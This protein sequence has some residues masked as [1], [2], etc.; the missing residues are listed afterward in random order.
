L[1]LFSFFMDLK[2]H[3]EKLREKYVIKEK[4]RERMVSLLGDNDAEEFFD[5]CYYSSKNFIRVNTLKISVKALKVR[6]EGYGWKIN[7]IVKGHQEIFLIES[8]LSPGELGKT[9]EHLLGYYY[10]QDLSSMLSLIALMPSSEDYFLD[11]CA[12]P[13]SKTTQAAAMMENSGCIIANEISLGRIGILNT[14]LERCGVSNVIVTRADGIRFCRKL[15][16]KSSMRFDKILVDAPCSGEGT[17]RK[18]LATLNMWNLKTIKNLSRVQKRLAVEALKC[19]K[20][21][22][23]MVYSTCTFAPEENEEVVDFLIKNF[24][25]EIMDVKISGIK[26]RDGICEW[27]KKDYDPELKKARRLYPQENDSEGFFLCKFR[28]LSDKCFL[29]DK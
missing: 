26:L 9:K 18:S 12:S 16:D 25:I 11:L 19:L 14:N 21:G 28:K 22:G 1:I 3:K 29:E 17:I 4:F 2:K 6:L 8:K 15:R 13:G 10:V 23:E 20:V 27:G 7:Q 24:D 5:I